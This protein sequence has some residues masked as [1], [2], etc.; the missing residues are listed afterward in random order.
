MMV[1]I[2]ESVNGVRAS[3]NNTETED[4]STE[5]H[6]TA[7][8]PSDKHVQRGWWYYS[9]SLYYL[10]TEWKSWSESRQDCRERGADLVIINSKEEQE[11][12]DRL[13]KISTVAAWIGLTDRDIEGVWKWVDDTTLTTGYWWPNEPN[14][15]NGN[16]DCAESAPSEG[17]LENW[18]DLSCNE[19]RNYICEK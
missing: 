9:S 19:K 16:E 14:D 17:K 12:V 10:S 15:H 7:T 8:Q 13:K 4:N 11:F 18:N 1:D 2:Y 6:S 3:E 5:R